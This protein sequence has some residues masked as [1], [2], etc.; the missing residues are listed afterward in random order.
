MLYNKIFT[1]KLIEKL[2]KVP[3]IIWYIIFGL[4]SLFAS[5]YAL[6]LTG[7][8]IATMVREMFP[9]MNVLAILI[10]SYPILMLFEIVI[11]EFI[12]YLVYTIL[13]NRF[14][15]R[16]SQFDFVFRLRL[17][18][19]AAYLIIGIVSMVYFI[20]PQAYS[21]GSAVI[22]V[23]VTTLLLG[24]FLYAACKDYIPNNNQ[25]DAYKYVARLYLGIYLALS[26][27]SFVMLFAFDDSVLMEYLE[28]G[29]RVLALTII[30]LLAYFQYLKLK[31]IPPEEP[32]K[33][34]EKSDESVYKD[35][36]F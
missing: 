9:G 8:E 27:F 16:I 14:L 20:F 28:Y 15:I 24:M 11:F 31:Q 3:V 29:L 7:N 21:I 22:N 1:D 19:I 26:V 10:I 2:K 4:S 30:S 25:A 18:M 13:F 36:G 12:A 32:K 6:Q 17:V 35:F 34:K 5:A 23:V 33:E